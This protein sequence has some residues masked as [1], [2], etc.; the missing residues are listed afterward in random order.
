MKVEANETLFV[1]D[2]GEVF[3]AVAIVYYYNCGIVLVGVLS[4]L[5]QSTSPTLHM[6]ALPAVDVFK[7]QGL[8]TPGQECVSY[9]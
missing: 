6:Q 3:V 2:S 4:W 5:Q 9:D 8:A 7:W 1:P